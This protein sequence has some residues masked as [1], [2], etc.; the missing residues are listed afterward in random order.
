MGY[1]K[2]VFS[3]VKA[4]YAGKY[5]KAQ[6]EADARRIE[7]YATLPEIQ[8]LD[9]LLSRTGL[10]IMGAILTGGADTEKKIAEIREKNRLTQE[11]RGAILIAN[12]YPADYT[13][14]RY[15]CMACGDSGYV[16]QK[17]CVCMRK[18]LTMASFESSGLG[19]LIGTQTFDNFSLNYYQGTDR[20]RAEAAQRHLRTFAEGFNKETYRNYLLL[21]S[22]GL[23]KTHLSTAVTAEVI[24]RGFDVFYVTAVGMLGDFEGK[25][26]GSEADKQKDLSRYYEADLLIVDDLGTEIVNQFTLSCLYDVINSRLNT[27]RSTMLNT[28]LSRKELEDK[29]NERITSR[30][31]GEYYPLL[32][33]G[34]DIR[35]QKIQKR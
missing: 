10:D 3:R 21:G 16:G 24:E 8:S 5:K 31:F 32:F 15:E 1:N 33:T 4:E 23:G 18:A 2:E 6:A 34:S 17:M 14:V 7:L 12:G 20:D 26:F 30:L 9:L 27:H 29:Y 28:N 11:K 13:D 25:R 22:T 35:R 19:A